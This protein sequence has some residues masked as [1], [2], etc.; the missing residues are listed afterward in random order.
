[1]SEIIKLIPQA[2]INKIRNMGSGG[3]QIQKHGKSPDIMDYSDV[4]ISEMSYGIYKDTKMILT[5]GDYFINLNNVVEIVCVLDK[6]SYIR[7]PT[8]NDFETNKHNFIQ[9][10]RT[11]WVSGYYLITKDE[12]SGRKRHSISNL[13]YKLRAIKKGRNYF[14]G[15]YSVSNHDLM[16]T[17]SQGDAPMSLY[18]PIQ[19]YINSVI[20]GKSY[21]IDNFKVET[22]IK[23]TTPY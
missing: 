4:E 16:R 20:Y 6:V 17:F 10:I 7:N 18:D 21:C 13:L 23:V 12:V 5:D 14:I 8:Q 3:L 9:N 11:F 15:L 1:M 19:L 22:D 2:E